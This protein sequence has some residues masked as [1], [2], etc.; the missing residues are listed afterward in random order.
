MAS[1]NE[2]L[3]GVDHQLAV[4]A[5]HPDTTQREVDLMR[6]I[7]LLVDALRAPGCVPLELM[8]IGGRHDNPRGTL[9]LE[10]F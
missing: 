9:D 2:I 10:K 7:Y 6:M 1:R 5:L 3:A 8:K 4:F